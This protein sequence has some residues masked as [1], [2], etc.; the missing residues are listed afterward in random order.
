MVNQQHTNNQPSKHAQNYQHL[1]IAHDFKEVR[2]LGQ[3]TLIALLVKYQTDW[4]DL[5]AHRQRFKEAQKSSRFGPILLPLREEIWEG[6][7]AAILHLDTAIDIN[8]SLWI[9]TGEEVRG[10]ATQGDITVIAFVNR[11]GLFNTTNGD[12]IR[13]INHPLFKN[14]HS[15]EFSPIQPNV[16][17]VSNTGL[18]SILELDLTSDTIIWEWD[19]W[20]HGY[21]KNPYGIYL[22]AK[23]AQPPDNT[24]VLTIAQAKQRMHQETPLPNHKNW[25]VVIDRDQVKHPLGLE[26]WQKSAEP[27]YAGYSLTTDKIVASFFVANEVVEIDKITGNVTVICNELS[28][29]H[30]MIAYNNGYL[31]C[32]TRKGTVLYFSQRHEL[33]TCFDFSTLPVTGQACTEDAEWLQFTSPIGDGTIIATIDSRRSKVFVWDPEKKI[34]SAYQYKPEWSVHSVIQFNGVV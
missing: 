1:S 9:N 32:D 26:K 20:A 28:R 21:N 4:N 7:F 27:N 33:L 22:I 8:T 14:L 24:K 15:V 29:P 12:L 6:G 34:Y 10:I 18:D 16:V 23:G 11:L 17:L 25:G 5:V 2:G 13:T 19:A 31:A 3:N 30:G